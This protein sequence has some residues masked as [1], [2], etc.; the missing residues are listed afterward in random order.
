MSLPIKTGVA[1]VGVT[2]ARVRAREFAFSAI[3]E[4]TRVLEGRILVAA[5]ILR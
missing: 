5:P 1:S 2:P 3:R 4:L